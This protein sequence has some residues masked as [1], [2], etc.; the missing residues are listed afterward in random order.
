M[1][2]EPIAKNELQ[3]QQAII[4]WTQY[5]SGKY[6]DLEYIYHVPNEGKR[7]QWY[8]RQLVSA[9]LRSGVPDLVLPSPRG[10]Y[11]GLYIELK[12]QGRKPTENQKKWMGYLGRKQYCTMVCNG[13]AEAKKAIEE[14][15]ELPQFGAPRKILKNDRCPFC[16]HVVPRDIEGEGVRHCPHCGTAID[17]RTAEPKEEA[18]EK[19]MKFWEAARAVDARSGWSGFV[20]PICG[21]EAKAHEG[22]L[23]YLYAECLQ[24]E[25]R[26]KE[27]VNDVG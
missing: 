19:V 15:M 26:L 7:S 21:G 3:E 22:S 27:G 4:T 8:G 10:Q 14:Y 18:D 12:V 20:C 24:C 2:N 11:H 17:W 1:L 6:P 16:D 9:G 5:M 23:D 25:T 13:F